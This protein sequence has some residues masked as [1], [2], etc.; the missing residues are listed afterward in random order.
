MISK[1]KSPKILNIANNSKNFI[2]YKGSSMYPILKNN[3]VLKISYYKNRKIKKGD[4]IVFISPENGQKNIHRIIS[5]NSGEIRTRG[6]N[7]R[8]RDKWIL[9]PGNVIGYVHHI[10]RRNKSIK[11]LGGLIGY[12][13][14][15]LL[16]IF[17][18]INILISSFIGSVYYKMS[19]SNIIRQLPYFNINFKVISFNRP[20][21][22]EL[23]LF[24]GKN[25]IGRL[26]PG[27]NIW[28]IK[29]PFR[30]FINEGNLPEN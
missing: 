26:L 9:N 3:D 24:I 25:L 8:N 13:C 29:P 28:R 10:Y 14:S 18:R 23:Q 6:D 16:R 15:I 7:N 12:L 21:G 19:K 20:S 11:V 1:Y 17:N 22:K 27:E 5:I 2:F 4:I 30:L